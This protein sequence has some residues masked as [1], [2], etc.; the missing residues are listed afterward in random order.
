MREICS[1][2]VLHYPS[3][4]NYPGKEEANPYVFYPPSELRKLIETEEDCNELAKIKSALKQ[5]QRIY[6]YPGF[7]WKKMAVANVLRVLAMKMAAVPH[8]SINIPYYQD[9]EVPQGFEEIMKSLKTRYDNYNRKRFYYNEQGERPVRDIDTGR[10]DFL[11][12]SQGVFE[13]G[14]V[15]PRGDGPD[16]SGMEIPLPGTGGNI[17]K[18]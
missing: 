3:G 5:W 6:V 18:I 2:Y 16:P 13:R 8:P 1:D 4:S 11:S 15:S 7:P 12:P 14:V 9:A 10:G 17:G